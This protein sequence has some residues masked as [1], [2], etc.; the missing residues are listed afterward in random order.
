MDVLLADELIAK[1]VPNPHRQHSIPDSLVQ[2]K[3]VNKKAPPVD[4]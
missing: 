2:N 1:P 3:K 4:S